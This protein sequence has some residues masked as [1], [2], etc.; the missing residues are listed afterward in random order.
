MTTEPKLY[1]QQ[2]Y[3]IWKN[4]CFTSELKTREGEEIKVLDIGT[5]NVDYAGADFKNARILLM[6]VILKLTLIIIIGNL[7]GITLTV[8]IIR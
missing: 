3:D 5:L 8:N 1:E 6:L 2:L 7:T 4:Q